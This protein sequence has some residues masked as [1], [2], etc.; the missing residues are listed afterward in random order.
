MIYGGPPMR[1][2][3]AFTVPAPVERAW[4]ALLDVE[5]VAPCLPGA[6]LEGGDGTEY[7]GSMTVSAWLAPADDG[8]HVRVATEIQVGGPA[9]QFGRGVMQDVSEKL[10][11]Q[12]ADCL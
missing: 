6:A 3:N 8:T 5:R 12:F 9:A 7:S 2:E 11:R 1:L 4:A 10:M